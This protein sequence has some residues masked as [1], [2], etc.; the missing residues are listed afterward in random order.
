M[1][2]VA[3]VAHPPDGSPPP[4]NMMSWLLVRSCRGIQDQISRCFHYS[5]AAF[6]YCHG[7]VGD[8]TPIV[9]VDDGSM[10]FHRYVAARRSGS[11]QVRVDG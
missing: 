1:A 3:K 6:A 4:W 8:E 5:N 10:L 9:D 11:I 2:F 7:T